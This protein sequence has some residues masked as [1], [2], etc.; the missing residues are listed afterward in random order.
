MAKGLQGPLDKSNLNLWLT[1]LNILRGEGYDFSNEKMLELLLTK[2]TKEELMQ[3]TRNTDMRDGLI[4]LLMFS[5]PQ[6][7]PKMIERGLMKAHMSPDDMYY[8]QRISGTKRLTTSDIEA[9]KDVF[10]QLYDWF[11]LVEASRDNTNVVSDGAILEVLVQKRG[12]Q[13]AMGF[14]HWLRREPG[15]EDRADSLLQLL[16]KTHPDKVQVKLQVMLR[17]CL[18]IAIS[19]EEVFRMLPIPPIHDD[20]MEEWVD[21]FY[22]IKV[23]FVY[24]DSFRNRGYDFSDGA[25][26]ETLVQ[27]RGQQ[28][29]MEFL[30][31]FRREPDMK[32]RVD[33][34]QQ[35]LVMKYP[36]MLQAMFQSCLEASI[37]PEEVLRLIPIAATHGDDKRVLTDV[38]YGIKVWFVYVDSFRNRGYDFSDGAIVETLV[39]NRGQQEAMEFLFWFRREPDMK[40]RVDSLQQLLVMKY[41]AMLPEMLQ[42]CLEASISPEEVLRLIPIAATHGDDKRVLTDVFSVIKVWFVYV[43]SFRG[44]GYDFSDGAIVE[45]LVQN[46]GQQEAMEFLFW[47]R[48]E[49]DMKDRVDSLQLLLVMKHPDMLQAMFQSCLEAAISP[50]EVLQMLPIPLTLDDSTEAV[51]NFS[52]MVNVWS[53][54]VSSFRGRGYVFSND[55]VVKVL[56]QQVG[57]ERMEL[58]IR[59]LERNPRTKPNVDVLRYIFSKLN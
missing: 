19:P 18:E 48:R 7:L 34:L 33:S 2:A 13:E 47:F 31:W 41:P 40:D 51:T 35:L 36:A 21:V 28:E 53:V 5:Y 59:L 46:R 12:Q 3:I 43:D 56:V 44:R 27:N 37:S 25:I 39:Q 49:P 54:Y 29:A 58:F 17:S 20:G 50:E 11:V 14:L 15:M 32:D 16:V 1:Y 22:V 24:V 9:W 38:F 42:S 23:W 10:R 8:W 6:M 30:F 57:R 26:V 4:R 55:A 45:T 52:S